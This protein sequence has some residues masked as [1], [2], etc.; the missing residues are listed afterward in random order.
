MSV[1]FDFESETGIAIMTARGELTY[2]D[3][4]KNGTTMW[5]AATGEPKRLLWD[6][7]EA[8]YSISAEELR[9]LGEFAIDLTK[10][11]AVMNA[12]VVGRDMEFGLSRMFESFSQAPGIHTRVF[13]DS[14]SARAWLRGDPTRLPSA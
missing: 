1:D 3:G 10:G 7:R 2:E 8:T 12:F 5:N 4:I 14:S 9:R 13:R 11:G 6:F